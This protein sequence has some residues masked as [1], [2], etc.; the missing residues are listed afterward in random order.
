MPEQNKIIVRGIIET[1]LNQKNIAAFDELL[2]KDFL[3]HNPAPGV[4]SDVGGL[5]KMFTAL[6]DAFPDL[7]ATVDDLIA[8]EDKVAVRFTCHG[9][10]KG[11]FMGVLP[12][13]RRVAFG[14]ITI[15]RLSDG[16]VTERW[17]LTDKF[18]ILQQIGS[19]P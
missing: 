11:A 19:V 8:E 18:G 16:K 4:P 6:L 5:K 3:N 10:H 12:T 14:Q 17:N 13:H 15:V 1:V 2:S 9:T 7:Q